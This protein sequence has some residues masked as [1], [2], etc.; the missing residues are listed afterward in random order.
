M[1][2]VAVVV[3]A[4]TTTMDTTTPARPTSKLNPQHILLVM[5]VIIVQ[6]GAK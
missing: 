4:A 6:D 1:M 3:L 2:I 5:A